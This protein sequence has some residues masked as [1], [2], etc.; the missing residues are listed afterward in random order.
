MRLSTFSLITPL[1]PAMARAWHLLLALHPP[2]KE[3]CIFLPFELPYCIDFHS[4]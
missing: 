3:T 2:A 1:M 4:L